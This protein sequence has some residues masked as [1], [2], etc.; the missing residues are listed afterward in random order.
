MRLPPSILQ[1]IFV[2]NDFITADN[3][4]YASKYNDYNFLKR[5][6]IFRPGR[7]RGKVVL[8][9]WVRPWK[10]ASRN[11]VVAAS[12]YSTSLTELIKLKG[13]GVPKVFGVNVFNTPNYSIS[14]PIGLTSDCDDSPLHRI[15]G[16]TRHLIDASEDSY[17]RNSYDGSIYV[18][19]SVNNN[20][21]QRTSLLNSLKGIKKVKYDHFDPTHSGR[22]NYLRN[23]RTHSLVVCP[24]GNGID[25]HRL[26]ETIYM[27]GTPVILRN[28]YLPSILNSLPVIQLDD[29]DQ[30][31][32]Q[33][34]IESYWNH[35]QLR[36][37][38]FSKIRLSK[39]VEEFRS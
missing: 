38:D 7:W 37:Y 20:I 34:F 15:Y 26:W 17:P 16:N 5:D 1:E 32:D 25:T 10:F 33:R 19:F 31:L 22:I 36:N 39:I 35:L 30:I 8:P 23:L 6:F 27:G 3:I 18:N 29:W 12:D 14:I 13:L 28:N 24:E 2:K 11:L 9:I 21:S 4:F